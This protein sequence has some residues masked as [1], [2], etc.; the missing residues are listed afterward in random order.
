[1]VNNEA[2]QSRHSLSAVASFVRDVETTPGNSIPTIP[3][4]MN[5]VT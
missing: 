1:M 5:V 3:V 2:L 4:I